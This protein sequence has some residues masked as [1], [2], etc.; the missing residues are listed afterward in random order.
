MIRELQWKDYDDIISNYY[1]F[2]DEVEDE[3]PDLGLIFN[4]ERPGLDD[5]V[6][7]FSTLFTDILK[8]NAVAMVAEVDGKAVGICD[9]HRQRPGSEL[10]HK[11]VVGMAIRKEY[12][13]RGIG[14]ELLNVT[15]EK[16][17]E[18]YELL[19]LSVF[20]TNERAISLY[21]NAG[22]ITYGEVPKSIKRK[23]RYFSEIHMYLVL[24]KGF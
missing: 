24:G 8:G 19:L 17:R 21:R 11:G 10:S 18:S 3:N 1:S 15:I 7:W 23:A 2:Y 14:R 16:C 13:G 22:F 5:E 6:I 20:S 4:N 12:R 9:V